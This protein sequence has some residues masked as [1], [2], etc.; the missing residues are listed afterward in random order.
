MNPVNPPTAAT[1]DAH[2]GRGRPAC[3]LPQPRRRA[4]R[5]GAR[6]VVHAGARAAGHR[7]RVGLRQ[8]ADR[9]RHPGP[10]GARAAWSPRNGWSFDGIDLLHCSRT[11]RR[12]CA[13]AASRWCCRT[14]SISLNPVMT[15]G[16]QMVETLRAHS[17]RLSGPRE[18]REGAAGRAGAVQI[19]DPNACSACTRTRCRAAWASAP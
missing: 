15:I 11:Q 8:V 2:P 4:G 14:P 13:A 3:G 16:A 19:D 9:A 18:A 10:D 5:C 17:R 1:H 12:R 6:R 7:G